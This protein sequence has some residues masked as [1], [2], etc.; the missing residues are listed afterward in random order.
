MKKCLLLKKA[1]FLGKKAQFLRKKAQFL[2][3][4]DPRLFLDSYL[5]QYDDPCFTRTRSSIG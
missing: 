1:R 5:S 4:S 3:Q 2:G